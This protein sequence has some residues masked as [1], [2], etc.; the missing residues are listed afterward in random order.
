MFPLVEIPHVSDFHILLDFS[1]D[2]IDEN[3]TSV[4]VFQKV[5]RNTKNY[6]KY[7][8]FQKIKLYQQLPKCTTKYPHV[9]ESTK[10]DIGWVQHKTRAPDGGAERVHR[11]RMRMRR[12]MR[13]RMR[14]GHRGGIG[15]KPDQCDLTNHWPPPCPGAQLGLTGVT[16]TT[17]LG[18]PP[19]LSSLSLSST[20]LSLKWA[21]PE[22]LCIILR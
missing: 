7:L 8:K 18:H 4:F 17:T 22:A 11:W 13:M 3:S 2:L 1:S 5:P 10:K 16:T 20:S 15:R 6:Q 19:S 14:R 9:P 21:L 12:R